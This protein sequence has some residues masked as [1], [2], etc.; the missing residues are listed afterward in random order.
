MTQAAIFGPLGELQLAYQGRFQPVTSL[1][2]RGSDALAVASLSSFRQ[3]WEGTLLCRE[4]LEAAMEFFQEGLIEPRADL[5]SKDQ[6][7]LLIHADQQRAE[8]LSCASGFRVAA[9]DELLLLHQLE[10]DPGSSAFACFIER[11]SA[12]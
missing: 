11:A 10:L 2:L 6:L 1:H 9:N 7:S 12:L 4:W 3:I 8:V 5:A